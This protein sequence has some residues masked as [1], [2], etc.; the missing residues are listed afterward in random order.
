METVHWKAHFLIWNY[1]DVFKKLANLLKL[2]LG[3]FGTRLHT[4]KLISDS[5][6]KHTENFKFAVDSVFASGNETRC[7]GF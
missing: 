5:E 6:G 3:A 7:F 2:H 1:P 4:L